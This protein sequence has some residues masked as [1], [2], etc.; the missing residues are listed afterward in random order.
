MAGSFNPKAPAAPA[1]AWV[2]CSH[3]ILRA[4]SFNIRMGEADDGPNSWPHRTEAVFAA[5]RRLEADVIGVQ[6][7]FAWQ[8]DPILHALPE[9]GCLGAG[10]EDGI[11]AGEHS[12]VLYRRDRLGL[13]ASGTFWFSDTPS[14]PGSVTWGHHHPRICTWARFACPEGGPRFAVFNQHWDHES[15]PAREKSAD[16]LLAQMG[17]HAEGLPAIVMGD[18]NAEADNPAVG[19]LLEELKQTLPQPPHGT[20][21]GFSGVCQESPI[22]HILAAPQWRT[23]SA[24]IFAERTNGR[25]PSD[26]FPIWA[27]LELP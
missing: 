12:A 22:D 25:W 10:R 8:L 13:E 3:V 4:A 23:L 18:L 19:R 5:I 2:Y 14:V 24:G 20:F 7:A 1:L 9:Y 17:R 11:R 15:Q 6:E 21:H 26:H 16:M 27:D